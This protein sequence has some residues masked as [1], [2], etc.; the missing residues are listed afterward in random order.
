MSGAGHEAVDLGF[1]LP[2]IRNDARQ[3]VDRTV[4]VSEC[5]RLVPL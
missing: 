2:I 1:H 3:P 5:F 4:L